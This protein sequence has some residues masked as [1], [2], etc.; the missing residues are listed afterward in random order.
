MTN[1][2]NDMN[3][4]VTRGEF[5]AGMAELRADMKALREELHADFGQ[6]MRSMEEHILSGI[7]VLLDPYQS[8]EPRLKKLEHAVFES[9]PPKRTKRRRA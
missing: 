4:L 5:R 2:P 1:D 6:M 9:P 8:H 7:R 3:A